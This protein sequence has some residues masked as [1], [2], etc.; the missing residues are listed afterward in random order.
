MKDRNSLTYKGQDYSREII[1]V[2]LK[3][4]FE[5]GIAKLI[6]NDLNLGIIGVGCKIGEGAFYFLSLEDEGL[7]IEQVRENYTD[8]MLYEKIAQAII[9]LD[10]DLDEEESSY[11]MPI[12]MR[13]HLKLVTEYSNSYKE[14]IVPINWFE[15]TFIP[16]GESL[17][18]FLS[19]Y[20]SEDSSEIFCRAVLEQKMEGEVYYG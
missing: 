19:E 5:K 8:E 3:I 12:L 6:E 20:T 1:A 10:T 13:G 18:K 4:A 17:D 14:F 7:S 2:L 16:E 15:I 11:Y 9:D